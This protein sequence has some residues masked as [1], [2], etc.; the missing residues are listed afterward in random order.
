MKFWFAR[1]VVTAALLP[2]LITPLPPDAQQMEVDAAHAARKRKAAEKK[3]A[4]E[5]EEMITLVVGGVIALCSAGVIAW[6]V[7][8]I[9]TGGVK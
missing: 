4:E 3:H 5:V 1:V 8:Q 9:V 6:V 2:A 7:I